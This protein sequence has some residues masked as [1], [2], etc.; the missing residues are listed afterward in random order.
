MGSSCSLF[1]ITKP[2]WASSDHVTPW[3]QTPFSEEK[4]MSLNHPPVHCEL[5]P[6]GPHAPPQ[7]PPAPV[8]LSSKVRPLPPWDLCPSVCLEYSSLTSSLWW[9]VTA[10]EPF[11]DHSTWNCNLQPSR[12]LFVPFLPL[13]FFRILVIIYFKCIYLFSPYESIS[14]MR[15]GII[16]P[17]SCRT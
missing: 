9:N 15:A 6:C 2:E 12:A 3:L 7:Q 16:F 17:P 11:L 4:L 5:T 8:L 1:R 10:R 14:S 13:L